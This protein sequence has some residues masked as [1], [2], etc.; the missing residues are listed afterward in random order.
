MNVNIYIEESL[1]SRLNLLIKESGKTRNA[2]VRDALKDWVE[3]HE[4]HQWPSA[5]LKFKGIKNA[6]RFEDSRAEL[7]PL[8]EDPF[9]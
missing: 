5:I 1:N 7:L 6:P 9:A 3:R 2:I 8:N 4:H